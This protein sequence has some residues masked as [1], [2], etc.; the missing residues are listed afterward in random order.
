MLP[1]QTTT[2]KRM[3]LNALFVPVTRPMACG[4]QVPVIFSYKAVRL[5]TDLN[6]NGLISPG[7]TLTWTIFYFNPTP[8]AFPNFQITDLLDNKVTFSPSLTV[9]PTGTG[10]TASANGSYNGTSDINLLAPGATLGVNGR[11][12]IQV[13]TVVKPNQIGQVLNQTNASGINVAPGG[14]KSDALDL[15][16]QGVQGGIVAPLGS[17]LQTARQ[18]GSIRR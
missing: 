9:N 4:L 15:F 16:S 14:V 2:L 7:D 18:V 8:I 11:I 5:T 13:K 10:T 12:V 17:V 3:I 1:L 6:G